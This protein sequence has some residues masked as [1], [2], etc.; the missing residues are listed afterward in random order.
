MSVIPL[1]IRHPCVPPPCSA[2]ATAL[3]RRLG[4]RSLLGTRVPADGIPAAAAQIPGLQPE[5][6][7]GGH[8]D[9][10]CA[11]PSEENSQAPGFPGQQWVVVVVM[12]LALAVSEG[13]GPRSI[14]SGDIP[15]PNQGWE[16]EEERRE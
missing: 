13:F 6:A 3:S 16:W 4:K 8:E 11:L 14:P 5:L 2:M 10:S 7:P 12:L 15:D 9:G 1:R